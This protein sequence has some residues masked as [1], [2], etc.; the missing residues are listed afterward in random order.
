[1]KMFKLGKFVMVF[2]MLVIFIGGYGSTSRK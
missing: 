2:T 1:M